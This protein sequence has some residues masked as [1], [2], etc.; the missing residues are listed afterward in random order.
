MY[1]LLK[2]IYIFDEESVTDDSLQKAFGL[3]KD[4]DEK[5]I[6]FVAITI[7]LSGL[8]WSGD[9]ELKAGLSSKGFHSFFELE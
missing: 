9:N 4:V 5:D 1:S 8:L 7:E 3:C 6:P 2:K